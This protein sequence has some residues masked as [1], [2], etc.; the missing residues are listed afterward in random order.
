MANFGLSHPWIA[1]LN[2]ET[3]KYSGAFRCGKAVNTSVSPN[4]NEA[5]LFADNQE[6]E[7]VKELKNAAVTLGTDSMPVAAAS[8]MFGHF[9]G[10]SG[11]EISNTNDA[12]N[13]VGYG[14]ITTEKVSGINKYRACV[15][16]K[17]LFTEGEESYDTKGDSIVFK[18]PSI[19]GIAMALE[20]G[21]WRKKS[22]YFA[23]EEEA[24]KWIQTQLD[25][26]EKCE[27]P[28]ASVSGGE[29]ATAQSVVLSTTTASAKIK[30][31]TDGTTPSPTNG[32]EYKSA[33]NV[34]ATTGLRAVA[35]KDGAENS[36]VMTE[37]YFITT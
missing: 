9:V 28:V 26:L 34:A 29:Y 22:P 7:H 35:Y 36:D 20:N 23:T 8:V 37:E 30:Y 31:T 5:S 2:T 18:T 21:E 13:Y 16:L 24:D 12:G 6:Q 14:F 15:L 10:E 1:K 27:T 17:A 25:V 4:Y 32:T 11:E 3:G 33:I 19:S